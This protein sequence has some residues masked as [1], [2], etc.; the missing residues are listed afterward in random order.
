MVEEKPRR[1]YSLLENTKYCITNKL[2][3]PHIH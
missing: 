3:M 2:L 1:V